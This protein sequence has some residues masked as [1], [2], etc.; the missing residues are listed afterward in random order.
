[1]NLLF[2][3]LSCGFHCFRHDVLL[4]EVRLKQG[5]CENIATRQAFQGEMQKSR[6]S[7]KNQRGF[8]IRGNVALPKTDKAPQCGSLV[9]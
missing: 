8:A 1:M 5:I 2:Y 7:V 6:A 3:T 9:R 4:K